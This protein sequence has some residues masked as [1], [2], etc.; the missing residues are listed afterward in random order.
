M[1]P[2]APIAAPTR[3]TL[4]L[5][6]TLV[7]HALAMAPIF[8]LQHT[9]LGRVRPWLWVAACGTLL[10]HSNAFRLALYTRRELRRTGQAGRVHAT[11]A[12]GLAGVGLLASTALLLLAAMLGTGGGAT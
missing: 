7:A 9:P 10:L 8:A 1:P 11:L 4:A 2:R 5:A 6:L 3:A 12:L